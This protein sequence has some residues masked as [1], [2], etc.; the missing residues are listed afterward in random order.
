MFCRL[1]GAENSKM[2]KSTRLTT[3]ESTKMGDEKFF[4]DFLRSEIIFLLFCKKKVVFVK[5][6]VPL[7]CYFKCVINNILVQ[8]YVRF[9]F[10]F[11]DILKR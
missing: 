1:I 10:F 11:S 4:G 3:S 9:I 8:I 6:V 5:N 2:W 7:R